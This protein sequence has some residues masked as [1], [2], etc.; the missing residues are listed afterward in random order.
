MFGVV[1]VTLVI[2]YLA[3]FAF[4]YTDRVGQIPNA[5]WATHDPAA[6]Y[7][8]IHHLRDTVGDGAV[9]RESF[10]GGTPRAGL[11]SWTSGLDADTIA[12][13]DA[14]TIIAR[15]WV[16]A[17]NDHAPNAIL[18]FTMD[19]IATL[20]LVPGGW[21]GQLTRE[22]HCLWVGQYGERWR[23]YLRAAV[24]P[25]DHREGFE[26]GVIVFDTLGEAARNMN[27]HVLCR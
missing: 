5:T 19:S 10:T 21:W 24:G 27:G 7:R 12:S 16:D 17:I 4:T 1:G 26:P 8:D 14:L 25:W 6:I 23:A 9:V 11:L 18:E 2:G 22:Q 15:R 13:P 3:A 20:Y